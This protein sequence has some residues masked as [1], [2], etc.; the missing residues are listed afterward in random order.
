MIPEEH[1]ILHGR[2]VSITDVLVPAIAQDVKW[3]GNVER[4][5]V[6]ESPLT[7][8]GARRLWIAL[9]KECGV[10]LEKG[11]MWYALEPSASDGR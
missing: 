8:D 11:D 2:G 10:E 7:R 1:I 4:I 3:I 6:S 5:Y 9:D